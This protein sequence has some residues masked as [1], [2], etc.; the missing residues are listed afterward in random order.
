MPWKLC[1]GKWQLRGLDPGC[2]SPG[3]HP[4]HHLWC[5]NSSQVELQIR[6]AK[7]MRGING[8]GCHKGCG[9]GACA[10][11]TRVI[12]LGVRQA[13]L[14]VG[15]NL[16]HSSCYQSIYFLTLRRAQATRDG[17]A[18]HSDHMKFCTTST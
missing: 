8:G 10:P 11:R 13:Q 17:P 5:F 2:L 1:A 3:P 9:S 14:R 12:L 7:G 15:Q 4:P 18:S 6:A 16:G